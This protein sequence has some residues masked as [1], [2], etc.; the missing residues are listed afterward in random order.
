[1][2]CWKTSPRF[3]PTRAGKKTDQEKE[4]AGGGDWSSDCIGCVEG[5]AADARQQ[6]RDDSVLHSTVGSSAAG[7][8]L[9][10]QRL[11]DRCCCC[12]SVGTFATSGGRHLGCDV[13]IASTSAS[14]GWLAG[15]LAVRCAA[16]TSEGRHKYQT[17]WFLENAS[18]LGRRQAWRTEQQG[19]GGG[20]WI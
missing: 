10:P 20:G 4:K 8:L 1:M 19:W 18:R 9:P 11:S 12:D 5:T 3:N 14:A 17:E 6:R 16:F 2:S 13:L 7:I 15:W